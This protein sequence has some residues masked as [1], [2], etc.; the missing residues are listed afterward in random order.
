MQVPE[1]FH[2][3]LRSTAVAFVSTLGRSGGPQVTPIWFVFDGDVVRFSLVDGRQKL[4]NLR[5]DPRLA[6]LVVDPA[7]PTF[8][9]ELRGTAT[10]AA[11]PGCDLEREASIKYTGR[12]SDGEPA[13]TLRF[14]AAV[15]VERITSQLGHGEPASGG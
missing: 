7:R 14:A 12:W 13:G 2:P 8:Y 6:V 10:L 1:H 5:R 9:V 3:L 15:D 11:D 4:V